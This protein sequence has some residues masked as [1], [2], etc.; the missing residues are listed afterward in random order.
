MKVLDQ[1]VDL[2][3]PEPEPQT[4]PGSVTL[5]ESLLR[6]WGVGQ[7]QQY[8]NLAG[9]G[10]SAWELYVLPHHDLAKKHSLPK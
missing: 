5:T 2:D 10:V 1:E 7:I 6:T 8:C 4:A 9:A 3:S